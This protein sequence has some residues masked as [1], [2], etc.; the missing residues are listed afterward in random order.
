MIWKDCS[1]NGGEDSDSDFKLCEKFNSKLKHL[2]STAV[3]SSS[4][5]SNQPNNLPASTKGLLTVFDNANASVMATA[6]I[7]AGPAAES[8]KDCPFGGTTH[9]SSMLESDEDMSDFSSNESDMEEESRHSNDEKNES[10]PKDTLNSSC[11]RLTSLST[12]PPVLPVLNLAGT[13]LGIGSGTTV[14]KIFTNTRERWRQQNVSGAFAEL[15]KLVPTHPPDKKLSKNEILRMAIRYIRLLTNVLEWQKKQEQLERTTEAQE[16]CKSIQIN[17]HGKSAQ[18]KFHT[19]N[20]ENHFTGN[21]R[22]NGNNL[23]MVVPKPFSKMHLSQKCS[24]E[25]NAGP[26]F[27]MSQIKM[28]AGECFGPTIEKIKLVSKLCPV[29][30][31]GKSGLKNRRKNIPLGTITDGLKCGDIIGEDAGGGNGKYRLES[32]IKREINQCQG[33]AELEEGHHSED[34]RNKKNPEDE[35]SGNKR[36]PKY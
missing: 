10:S 12:P 30:R 28:E 24:T 25:F 21:F 13:K 1:S 11:S 34:Q 29:G 2:K 14:R 36:K 27:R 5:S 19:R 17:G 6:L 33:S 3:M 32:E 15:R 22:E 35:V 20:N 9:V 23:L 18:Q 4:S 31:I 16:S 7:V 26:G 8:K